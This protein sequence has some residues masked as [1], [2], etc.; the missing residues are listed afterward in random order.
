MIEEATRPPPDSPQRFV[1]VH[2]HC[3]PSLD[4]GPASMEDAIVLCEHL[5]EDNIESVIATPHQLGRYEGRTTATRIRKA[6]SELTREL[7]KRNIALTISPG[8]EV[9]LDERIGQLLAQDEVLTLADMNRHLLL[10][11]Y[12]DVFIDVG[13]LLEQ[14]RSQ[15]V[16]VLIAHAERNAPLHSHLEAL[17]RWMTQGIGVQ[18]TA[19][20]LIGRFGARARQ[21]AWRLAAEGWLAVV[22]SDAHDGRVNRSFMSVAF[23]QLAGYFSRELAYLVCVENPRRLFEGRNLVPAFAYARQEAR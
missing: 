6:T 19:G 8:A 13:P 17:R 4:D 14:L 16:D 9:R 12:S 21:A 3:L 23:E 10:E 7:R 18:V 11:L 2:C 15:G 20:S 5:V 1:D 22:A